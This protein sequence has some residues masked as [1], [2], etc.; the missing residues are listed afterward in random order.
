MSEDN[1]TT[2]GLKAAVQFVW[3]VTL[4]NLA[5]QPGSNDIQDH[6]EEDESVVD[7]AL[8]IGAF[9]FLRNSVLASKT[10]HQEEFYVRRFHMLVTDFIIQMPLKIKELRNRGDEAA[11]ILMVHAMEG[12]DA[13]ANLRRDFEHFMLLIGDLYKKDPLK[14]QLALEYWCPMEPSVSPT[15]GGFAGTYHHRP[16]QRQVTLFKFVRLAGD[17]LPPSLYIPYIEM[18][19]GL[20]NGPQCAFYCFNLLKSNGKGAGN[21]SSVSW[22]HFFI[23]INQYYSSLRQEMPGLHDTHIYRHGSSRGITSQEMEGLLVVLRLTQQIAKQDDTARITLCENQT[24]LPIQLLFGFLGCSI[25]PVLK[26]EILRT[27]SAFGKS[28]EI[29]ATLWQSLEAS[30]LLPTVQTSKASGI[31]IE[32][33]EVEARSEEFPMVLGF[34]DFIDTLTDIPVPVSL[35]VGF[36]APGFDPYLEFLRDMVFLKFNTRAYRNPSEKWQV[37]AAVLEILYKMLRDYTPQS[38]DFIEQQVEMQ[39]GG[40]V[41]AN[42]PPGYNLLVH[43]LNDSP[44]LKLILN[45]VLEATGL[46]DQ[47]SEFPGKDSLQRTALL[48]LKMIECTLEKET[49]FLDF[50]REYSSSVMV[51]S[52]DKLLMGISP[53]TGKADHLVN[54]TKYVTYNSFNSELALS[55]VKILFWVTQSSLVQSELV[56]MLTANQNVYQDILH[57]FV[58]CLEIEDIEEF[59]RIL[60]QQEPD[61]EVVSG[62]E[63]RNATRQHIVRV[64]LFSLDQPAPNLAHLLLG[65]EVRKPVTATNI[66]EPG[67]LGSPKTCLHTILSLLGKGVDSRSGPTCIYEMPR[68]SELAYQLIYALCANKDTS[69]PT[70]R[71][72]RATHDFFYEH[73]QHLPFRHTA[74]S[75]EV[76]LSNQQSWLLK[77]V[78]LE[79]KIT[80]A[81]RQRSHTQRLLR[82]LLEDVQTSYKDPESA[83]DGTYTLADQSSYLESAFGTRLPSTQTITGSQVKRKIL[84]LLDSVDFCQESPTSLRLDYLDPA[85]VEKVIELFEQKNEYG[86]TMCNVQELHQYLIQELNTL[87]GSAAAGQRSLIQQEIQ[88]VLKNVVARNFVRENMAAKKHSFDAWRQMTEVM[89]TACPFDILKPDTRQEFILEL[90]Q[91]LLRKVA[92]PE[93]RQELIAPVAGVILILMVNLRQSIVHDQS[94]SGI[95]QYISMLDTSTASMSV[96]ASQSAMLGTASSLTASPLVAVLKG[97]IEFIMQSSG[98]QQ[99][100]RAHL[101]GALVNFLQLPQKPKEIPS[102]EDKKTV[103]DSAELTEYEKLVKNNVSVITSYGENLMEMV[104]RDTCD[105]H[106]VGRMLAFSVIDCIVSFDKHQRWL[107][108]LT[109]K[110][111]LRHLIEGIVQDDQAL[112]SMLKPTPEPLKALYVYESKMSLLARFA[113][114]PRGAQELLH[115]GLLQRLSDCKFFDLRPE[116]DMYKPRILSEPHEDGDIESFVPSIMAR[117]RQ[118]LFPALKVSL[119]IMTS[120]GIQHLEAAGQGLQFVIAHRDVFNAIMRDRL[121][122]T[123]LAALQELSLT[124]AVIYRAAAKAASHDVS[125]YEDQSEIEYQGHLSGIQRQMLAL[126]LRYYCLDQWN[127]ELKNMESS[128][129]SDGCDKKDE[130]MEEILAISSNITA[131]CRTVVSSSA[132]SSEFCRML[133]TASLTEARSQDMLSVNDFQVS[134]VSGGRPPSLGILVRHLRQCVFSFIPAIESYK[135]YIR[136]LQNINEIPAEELRELSSSVVTSNTDKMSTHQRQ[137]LAS[138]RL[139]QITQHKAKELALYHYIIENSIFL[140]WRHLEFYLIHCQPSDSTSSLFPV[141]TMRSENPRRLQDYPLYSRDNGYQDSSIHESFTKLAGAS[142]GVTK[143]DL[144]QLKVDAVACLNEP[145]FEK[146]MT[147][148]ECYGKKHT[149]CSFVPALVRRIR[150]LLKLHTGT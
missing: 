57:G 22:D 127:K 31:Q 125:L 81:N 44:M 109:S 53:K 93:A 63:I 74:D 95:T 35:G 33:E 2:P 47:Y 11:R 19:T 14:L 24:W 76:M 115:A 94:D 21:C 67:V 18:L 66:Q 150:Q 10:F 73:L 79:I 119:A 112:Q 4:R 70:M 9:S 104:C 20:A 69:S 85:T 32:L 116:Q 54:V 137:L 133:F 130:I 72:L 13:P 1:W 91:D 144:E 59:D 49:V 52:M 36:R 147:V 12:L 134:S 58:E 16:P 60:E 77:S 38:E 41:A 98:G 65:Y 143:E 145:L 82:L 88:S 118:L 25:P 141:A 108:F 68:F 132:S 89:L 101:Y 34:L 7:T 129:S 80:A 140:L 110:G 30:Q 122:Q 55:A 114:T 136:K 48:C 17:L 149:R 37:S 5:Q 45:I 3:G 128:I 29:A 15:S 50:L 138:K 75:K 120:L 97:L 99:R 126:V 139:T 102:L 86:I 56:R 90:L 105:G 96:L 124:T 123:N 27:L 103:L 71:Y 111:Y 87:Q 107:S 26:G 117:Y 142:D 39:G 43:L 42:K 84:S 6:I 106:D 23:S 40:M 146:L 100:V 64:L 83:V 51:T 61:D 135:Q 8:F 28:P 92:N 62:G 78:A 148:D 121:V 131:Y 46:L 113:M